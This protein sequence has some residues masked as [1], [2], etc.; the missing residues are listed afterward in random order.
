MRVLSNSEAVAVKL[1]LVILMYGA[2]NQEILPL[3]QLYKYVGK[4]EQ[5]LLQYSFRHFIFAKVSGYGNMNKNNASST[6]CIYTCFYIEKT[7]GDPAKI[8][9]F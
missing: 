6:I 8:K 5:K 2:T 3:L 7:G 9:L 4:L 1:K